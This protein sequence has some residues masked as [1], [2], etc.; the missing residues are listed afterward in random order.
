MEMD[1]FLGS[2]RW[3]ILEIIAKS[4][5]SPMEIS[6]QIN[7]SVAYVSQQLKLLEAAGLIKKERTGAVQ[8]GAP[9]TV[10]SITNEILHLTALVNKIPAKKLIQLTDYH[11]TILKIWLIENQEIHKRIE[12][13][14]WRLESEIEDIDA[15]IFDTSTKPRVLIISESK[16]VKTQI[17]KFLSKSD[18]KLAVSLV[19]KKEIEKIPRE[20]LHPIHD[21]K[22]ILMDEKEMKGGTEKE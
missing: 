15:I 5:S 4:P 14:Y 16:K 6:Q 17:E 22:H 13:L 8:K 3:N 2:P 9:R 20:D 7:T 11:N 12:K 1:T 21:P 10:F 19:S 18:G